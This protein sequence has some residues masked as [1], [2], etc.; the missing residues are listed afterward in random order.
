MV[1]IKKI[2]FRFDI[3]KCK[4]KC[5]TYNSRYSLVVTH[6]TTN[7]PVRSLSMP[8]RTGWPVF[9]DLWSYVLELDCDNNIYFYYLFPR[10]L[11]LPI[12]AFSTSFLPEAQTWRIS[13]CKFIYSVNSL[14][15][16]T[17][18]RTF[19]TVL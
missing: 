4:R 9:C 18:T 7:R 12:L 14:N 5:K 16:F 8:E 15:Q 19:K 17:L 1:A 3:W 10:N 11:I 6:L 2:E 13:K